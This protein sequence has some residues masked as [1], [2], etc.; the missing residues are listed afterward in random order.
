MTEDPELRRA[1]DDI[2]A[3]SDRTAELT[4]SLLAFAH[5]QPMSTRRRDLNRIVQGLD[6]LLR[7]CLTRNVALELVTAD[8][9]S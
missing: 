6:R 1:V 4:G 8:G 7:G 3:A 5:Q 2:L 9:F